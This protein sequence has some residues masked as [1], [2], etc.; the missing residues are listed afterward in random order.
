MQTDPISDYLARIKNAIMAG[1]QV[2]EIP[3]SKIKEEITKILYDQGYLL[4]FKVSKKG[5]QGT[6]L[7]A[8]KYDRKTMQSPVTDLKRVSRPGLRR[9]H[10]AK[11]IPQVLNGL[12]IAVVSTSRGLMTDKQARRENIGGEVICYVY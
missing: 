1:H 6:I 7:I 8:L 10:G 4:N 2:V 11:D 9:Y 3:S 5:P 12:G